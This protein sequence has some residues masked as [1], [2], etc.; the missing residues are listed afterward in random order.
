[1]ICE[2]SEKAANGGTFETEGAAIDGKIEEG[3]RE[4]TL[5]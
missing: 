2:Q 3:G 5:I 4:K 1:M